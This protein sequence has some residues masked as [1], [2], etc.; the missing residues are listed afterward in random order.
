[1]EVFL[2]WYAETKMFVIVNESHLLYIFATDFP[3]TLTE[4]PDFTGTTNDSA[5]STLTNVQIGIIVGCLIALICLVLLVLLIRHLCHRY[6]CFHY[7]V[8]FTVE[9][10]H[11]TAAVLI[12][13]LSCG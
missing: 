5:I 8:L 9:V 10:A 1:M 2:L 7:F 11:M 13:F 4:N 3:L 6:C 12:L